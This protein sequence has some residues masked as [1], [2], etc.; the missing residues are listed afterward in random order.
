M[1]LFAL[2]AEVAKRSRDAL[3][4]GALTPV[5][6]PVTTAQLL[7]G[8][9]ALLQSLENSRICDAIAPDGVPPE[10]VLEGMQK[11]HEL[12]AA[13]APPDYADMEADREADE[14]TTDGSSG[15]GVTASADVQLADGG[16]GHHR[17]RAG[18]A[19]SRTRSAERESGRMRSPRR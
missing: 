4:P 19:E 12:M 15:A 14:S 10:A 11:M 17:L 7:D 3:R 18:G 16:G 2:E 9:R 6:G 1:E 8:V 13:A 5:P